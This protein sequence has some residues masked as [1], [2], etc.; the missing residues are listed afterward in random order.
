MASIFDHI[1][2]QVNDIGGLEVENAGASIAISLKRIADYLK[3]IAKAHEPQMV[4]I[5]ANEKPTDVR[6]AEALEKLV[7]LA[8]PPRDKVEVAVEPPE[9]CDKQLDCC[10]VK[11]H[12]GVCSPF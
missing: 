3:T 9:V 8:A 2:P 12:N 11:G 6:I 4:V 1:E 5:T 10:M 7:V